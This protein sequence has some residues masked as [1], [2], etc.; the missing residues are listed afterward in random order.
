MI[1]FSQ[2]LSPEASQPAPTPPKTPE[3]KAQ[4]EGEWQQFFARPE[5]AAGLLQMGGQLMQPMLPGQTMAGNVSSAL[6]NGASTMGN[7]A[8]NIQQEEQVLEEQQYQRG[9]DSRE[10][11][12]ADKRLK[13]A[14][15]KTPA[16]SLAERKFAYDQQ[17][18][19]VNLARQLQNDQQSQNL[20]EAQIRAK[21]YEG[22][23]GTTDSD[24]VDA[25]Y[26]RVLE[27]LGLSNANTGQVGATSGQMAPDEAAGVPT[28]GTGGQPSAGQEVIPEDASETAGQRS[29]S[30][31]SIEAHINQ[32]KAGKFKEQVDQMGPG[33]AAFINEEILKY[34]KEVRQR[35]LDYY[36]KGL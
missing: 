5:I 29:Y 35:M 23:L 11:A 31:E 24:E 28:A 21:I 15:Q 33:A 3:E 20:A 17:M 7:A 9:K 6:V 30:P 13:I 34:P 25:T 8:S 32:L 2:L 26:Q 12:R 10:E 27:Q 16:E 18:D 22:I 36:V 4:I 1:D 19:S 14:S